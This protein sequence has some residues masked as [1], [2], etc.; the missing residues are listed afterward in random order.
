M[1]IH[2]LHR[3]GSNNPSNTEQAQAGMHTYEEHFCAS[4]PGHGEGTM[5]GGGRGPTA[6]DGYEHQAALGEGRGDTCAVAG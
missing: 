6:G 1:L 4:L 5:V 2:L 3:L